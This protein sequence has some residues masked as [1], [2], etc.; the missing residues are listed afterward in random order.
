MRRIGRRAELPHAQRDSESGG[1]RSYKYYPVTNEMT[2]HFIWRKRQARS[3]VGRKPCSS[4]VRWFG[5]LRACPLGA[6]KG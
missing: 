4:R 3:G 2:T 6:A 1:E 5:N